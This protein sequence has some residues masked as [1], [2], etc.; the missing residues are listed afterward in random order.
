M[1]KFSGIILAAGNGIRFGE[2]KQFIQLKGKPIWQ[3]NNIKTIEDFEGGV[4]KLGDYKIYH[5]ENSIK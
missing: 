5:N 4:Y 2:K 1:T 3:W